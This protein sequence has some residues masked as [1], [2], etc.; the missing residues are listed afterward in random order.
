MKIIVDTRE[1][2]H[3]IVQILR[4]FEENG[5]D[6]VK[7]KLNV[8]DYYNPDN[9]AVVVDRKQNLGEVASNLTSDR[10]RFA[11]EAHRATESG[12]KLIVLIEHG[13]NVKTLTDVPEWR[14]PIRARHHEAISGRD[15]MEQML[16]MTRTHAVEWRFCDKSETGKEIIKILCPEKSS[17]LR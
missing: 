11:R 7:Q 1:K 10:A 12:L 3:A 4:T 15:L 17:S 2:P 13:E 6:Y 8:G 5:I 16:K 14:N 9:P